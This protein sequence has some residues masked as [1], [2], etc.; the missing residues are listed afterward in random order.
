MYHIFKSEKENCLL[1]RMRGLVLEE[2][3]VRIIQDLT[4]QIRSMRKGFSLALDLRAYSPKPGDN[5]EFMVRNA[6]RVLAI[7]KPAI[8]IRIALE[9]VLK[10]IDRIYGEMGLPFS[11]KVKNGASLRELIS[12]LSTHDLPAYQRMALWL[13]SLPEDIEAP[14]TEMLR[15]LEKKMASRKPEALPTPP[16]IRG[17]SITG[18]PVRQEKIRIQVETDQEQAEEPYLFHFSY[19]YLSS[20]ENLDDPWRVLP[21]TDEGSNCRTW[22]FEQ[23]GKHEIRIRVLKTSVREGSAL[24]NEIRIP[25]FIVPQGETNSSHAANDF[26]FSKG[27]SCFLL[28]D[29]ERLQPT[30]LET[31]ILEINLSA[32]SLVVSTPKT[33]LRSLTSLDTLDLVATEYAHPEKGRPG[34]HII[35]VESIPHYFHEDGHSESALLLRFT[36]PLRHIGLRGERQA[37]RCACQPYAHHMAGKILSGHT[38]LT[39]KHHF[40]FQDISILG[41]GLLFSP[42]HAALLP[43]KGAYCTLELFFEAIEGTLA[44]IHIS[45]KIQMV[46]KEQDTKTQMFVAGFSFVEMD[47]RE[48]TLLARHINSLQLLERQR[49]L[50][51]K[52]H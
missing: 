21:E 20:L 34:L 9:P 49:L 2:E 43:E 37:F 27:A 36:L 33:P 30:F 32:Q 1:L 10:R 44:D 51:E 22:R 11:F 42:E 39:S 24:S 23:T 19:R 46:R 18:N 38:L 41:I 31:R 8:I 3:G 7:K 12:L 16:F 47:A 45:A 25:L 28:Q 35:A 6:L 4:S 40:V 50:N 13:A 14:L 15:D 52:K 48:E 17:F 5:A 26:S 29:R